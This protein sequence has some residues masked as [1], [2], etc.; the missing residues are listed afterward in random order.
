MVRL[1][2]QGV[3]FGTSVVIAVLAVGVSLLSPAPSFAA[4][5]FDARYLDGVSGPQPAISVDLA[6]AWDFQ[7]VQ[8]TS[9]P[10]SSGQTLG[11]Q[12]NC[13]NI[14]TPTSST[15]TIQVPGGGW[16][17]QGFTDVAEAV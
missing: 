9:C 17:K 4:S 16:V 6:G 12:P 2:Q 3:R 15:T 10:V 13:V 1:A 8:T 14:P 5:D 11:P 7:T